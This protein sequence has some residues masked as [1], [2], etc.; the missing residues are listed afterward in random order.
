M[1]LFTSSAGTLCSVSA[2]LALL[3][4]AVLRMDEWGERKVGQAVRASLLSLEGCKR[5][6]EVEEKCPEGVLS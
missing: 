3:A 1:R 5:R 2:W 6:S 4:E